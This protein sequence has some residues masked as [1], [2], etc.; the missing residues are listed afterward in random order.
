MNKPAWMGKNLGPLMAKLASEDGGIRK[1]ARG[2]LV[3]LGKPAVSSLAK[4]L[5]NSGSSQVRWEAAKALGEIGAPRSIP[6]LVKALEDNDSDVAWLAADALSALKQ[7]AWPELLRTLMKAGPHSESLRRG[8]H[9]VF[10]S[11]KENGFDDLLAALLKDL[12]PNAVRESA[13]IAA[14]AMLKR[15]KEKP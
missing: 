15:M 9:H 3:A 7:K 12:E 4:A 10:L 14:F 6:I 2:A 1:E 8:A 5:K 13:P 11:Q